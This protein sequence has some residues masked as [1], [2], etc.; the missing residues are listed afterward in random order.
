MSIKQAMDILGNRAD[1]ELV[2]MKKALSKL[3]TLNTP[4]ENERL[5]AVKVLLKNRKKRRT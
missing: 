4:E 1:W 3:P 2:R 5:E